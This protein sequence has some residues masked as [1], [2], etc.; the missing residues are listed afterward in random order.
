LEISYSLKKTFILFIGKENK[1]N[2]NLKLAK[3]KYNLLKEKYFFNLIKSK[4]KLFRR[5]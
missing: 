2:I 5:K 4:L 1:R 3:K